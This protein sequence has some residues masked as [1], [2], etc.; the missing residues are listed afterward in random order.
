MSTNMHGHQEPNQELTTLRQHIATLE[1]QLCERDNTVSELEARCRYT[2]HALHESQQLLQ[3][4]IDTMPQAIFWK[5]RDSIFRGCNATFALDAGFDG[6]EPIVGKSDYDLHWTPEQA[7]AFQQADQRIM[8]TGIAECHIAEPKIQSNGQQRWLKTSRIPLQ[9]DD[10]HV[11][12]ILGTYH[13]VTDQK[14]LEETLRASENRFRT[15]IESLAVATLIHQDGRFCYA[16]PAAETLS[17]YTQEELLTMNLYDVVHPDFQQMVVQRATARQRGEQVDPRYEIQIVVKSEEVRWVDITANLIQFDGKPSILVT[18]FDITDRKHAEMEQLRL[19]EQ[20]IETQR[21]T[22]QQLSTP[23][24]P[25]ADNILSMP[26][27]GTVDST[28]AQQ[29]METLLQGIADYQANVAIIDISG[30]PVIDT[31]VANTLIQTA[32]AVR[33]LGASII[34]TG[35]SPAMA[36]TLTHLDTDLHGIVTCSTLQR[37]IAYAMRM[38]S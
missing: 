37:G 17:L 15:L 31:Q 16:N 38:T 28:R 30:V 12:G 9:D 26:I 20:M 11:I 10:G 4:I 24:M 29:I 21:A 2:E 3:T 7:T 33:L 1:Q 13:D 6:P 19:R 32:Q 22:I 35:I 34:L 14:N 5:D 18:L 36:Q 8:E 25:L 27:I 23:L